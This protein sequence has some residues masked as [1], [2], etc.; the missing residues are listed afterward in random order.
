MDRGAWQ[1]TCSSWSHKQLDTTEWPMLSLSR[2]IKATCFGH[3]LESH[4]FMSSSIYENNFFLLLICLMSVEL[5]DQPKMLLERKGVFLP[6]T[7]NKKVFLKYVG[8]YLF[9]YPSGPFRTDACCHGNRNESK[10]EFWV[11]YMLLYRKKVEVELKCG[12]KMKNH[13]HLSPSVE[14]RCHD[15]ASIYSLK[16]GIFSQCI[17]RWKKRKGDGE[18]G[19]FLFPLLLPK[20]FHPVTCFWMLS[21]SLLGLWTVTQTYVSCEEMYNCPPSLN[22]KNT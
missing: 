4:I 22:F 3:S 9:P 15:C 18:K 2:S 19:G 11:P 20:L 10:W 16:V 13:F 6:Y 5:L 17:W 21:A 1:A 7:I 8:T 12:L 14:G